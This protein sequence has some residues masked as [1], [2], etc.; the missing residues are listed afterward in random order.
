MSIQLL[1][2]QCKSEADLRVFAE[3][4][5][6]TLMS[7]MKKCKQ[8]EDEN[9][10][11]KKL[12]VNGALPI[13]RSPSEILEIGTPEQEV[14]KREIYKLHQKSLDENQLTLEECKKLEVYTKILSSKYD[15]KKKNN[16]RE[17]KELDSDSL[18]AVVESK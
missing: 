9:A 15:E 12:V 7:V 6:K 10:E 13:V 2:D 14:A 3:S 1:I 18:L 11:L 5:T 8:L 4:Q 17:V 16:E